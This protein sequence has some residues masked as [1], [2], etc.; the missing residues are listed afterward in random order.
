MYKLCVCTYMVGRI[1]PFCQNIIETN[2]KILPHCATRIPCRER[3]TN[4]KDGERAR[5]QKTER[6]A[7]KEKER[8]IDREKTEGR[9]R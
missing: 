3:E 7:R 5:E 8:N 9:I 6:V 1:T 2:A 4:K